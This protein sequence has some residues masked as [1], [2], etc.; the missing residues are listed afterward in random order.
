MPT[1]RAQLM[2]EIKTES[3][4]VYTFEIMLYQK[5]GEFCENDGR[6]GLQYSKNHN[7]S[8]SAILDLIKMTRN[9]LLVLAEEIKKA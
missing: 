8:K 6:A 4:R 2:Q 7:S 9:E 5:I 1:D 3:K